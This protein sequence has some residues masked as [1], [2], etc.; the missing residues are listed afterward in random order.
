MNLKPLA[1]NMTEVETGRYTVL[2][3]YETPVAFIDKRY[4][5][6]HRTAKKWSVTTERHIS[7]WEQ[8]KQQIHSV[9]DQQ[10][11]FDNLLIEVK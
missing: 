10:E 4:S 1:A 6:M 3:S 9:I 2:F 7:K 5:V 11:V 8:I